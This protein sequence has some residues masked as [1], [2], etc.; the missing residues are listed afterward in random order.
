LQ[1]LLQLKSSDATS[2]RINHWLTAFF[3][4][5]LQNAGPEAA[6][7]ELLTAIR[8]YAWLTK[9]PP[10]AC[11]RYLSSMLPSWN[12]ETGRE[13]ILDLLTYL[14]MVLDKNDSWLAI[15]VDMEE[16]EVSQILC[17]IYCQYPVLANSN[18]L[19]GYSST[20]QFSSH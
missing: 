12:G 19:Y 6:I 10:S 13:V 1:K 8:D 7:L 14:P 16:T 15:D 17:V 20:R 9:K 3:E 2:R 4:D 18:S 11:F 5:Q